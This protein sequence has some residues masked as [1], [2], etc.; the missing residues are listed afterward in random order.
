M[1]FWNIDTL[2][3]LL[4]DVLM[5]SGVF[6]QI[7]EVRTQ[8]EGNDNIKTHIETCCVKQENWREQAV[9]GESP[10]VWTLGE[11]HIWFVLFASLGNRNQKCV[12]EQLMWETK[13]VELRYNFSKL[14]RF[15]LAQQNSCSLFSLRLFLDYCYF[16]ICQQSL[17]DFFFF[18]SYPLLENISSLS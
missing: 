13:Q 8:G 17:F 16:Y 1:G 18:S 10:T 12:E 5:R 2:S 7:R 11:K 15:L 6:S 4:F 3:F 9:S 14:C